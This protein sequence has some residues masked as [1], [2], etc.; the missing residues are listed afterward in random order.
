M[1][2]DY[3][4]YDEGET[5][6]NFMTAP[7]KYTVSCLDDQWDWRWLSRAICISVSNG[8]V[9][10]LPWEILI[11]GKNKMDGRPEAIKVPEKLLLTEKNVREVVCKH[12]SDY[13]W[14]SIEK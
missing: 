4:E 6:L 2:E 1:T 12:F 3:K 7:L 10:Q 5:T 9:P 14:C 11:L 8:D 13:G